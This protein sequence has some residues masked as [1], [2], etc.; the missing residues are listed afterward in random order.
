M[1]PISLKFH[2]VEDLENPKTTFQMTFT[3]RTLTLNRLIVQSFRVVTLA[4]TT[5]KKYFK[6]FDCPEIIFNSILLPGFINA[7]KLLTSQGV[8][9]KTLKKVTFQ[10]ISATKDSS[11]ATD[12]FFGHYGRQLTTISLHQIVHPELLFNTPT[13]FLSSIP[14]ASTITICDHLGTQWA[15]DVSILLVQFRAGLHSLHTTGIHLP[16]FFAIQRI[17]NWAHYNICPLGRRPEN[18]AFPDTHLEPLDAL[19]VDWQTDRVLQK[20]SVSLRVVG[21]PLITA[22]QIEGAL[23]TLLPYS[24]TPKTDRIYWRGNITVT[25]ICTRPEI[26]LV[27]DIVTFTLEND[28][29]ETFTITVDLAFKPNP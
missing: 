12:I 2:G 3:T 23:K 7:I 6:N 18:L 26:S 14:F 15:N 28:R 17:Q 25:P 22:K 29:H 8:R 16:I 10:F 19:S 21:N 27:P 4:D 20:Q 9:M 5:M 11:F 1:K 24:H 13:K